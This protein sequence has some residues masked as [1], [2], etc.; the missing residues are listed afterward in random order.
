VNEVA[1]RSFSLDRYVAETSLSGEPVLLIDDTW[2]TG[3]SAQSAAATLKA[4][5]AG[6]VA[7]VVIGRHVNREWNEND[8][9]LRALPPFDWNRCALCGPAAA[10]VRPATVQTR[11]A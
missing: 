9:R 10:P 3:S 5:G 8:R 2:T 4:A 11:L 6:V 7:A 1:P